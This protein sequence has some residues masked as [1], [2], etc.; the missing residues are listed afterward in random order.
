MMLFVISII[1]LVAVIPMI[2]NSSLLAKL[3]LGGKNLWL[4][5]EI[6]DQDEIYSNDQVDRFLLIH[7]KNSHQHLT[8]EIKK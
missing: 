3:L 7:I 5:T 8:A 6:F 4:G 1:V 2:I